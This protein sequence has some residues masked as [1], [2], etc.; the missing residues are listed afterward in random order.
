MVVSKLQ[1]GEKALYVIIQRLDSTSPGVKKC[2]KAYNT[3]K[4]NPK[5]ERN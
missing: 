1:C 4:E 5:G 3:M 2:F